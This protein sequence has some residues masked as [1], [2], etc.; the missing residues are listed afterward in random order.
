M[1]RNEFYPALPVTRVTL[2]LIGATLEICTDEIDDIH[3]LIAGDDNAVSALRIQTVGDQLMV[4]QPAASLAKSAAT[5]TWLQVTLRLPC[6]WKGSIDARSVSGW[7]NARGLAGADLSLDSVSGMVSGTDL[8]FITINARTITGD[9]KL[10]G[11]RCEKCSLGSTSGNLAAQ[12]AAFRTAGASTVTGRITLALAEPFEDMS[13][14]AVSGDLR[15][16]APITECD[17]LLRSVSGR[18][19]TRDV[20]ITEDAPRIRATTVSSDLDIIRND[21]NA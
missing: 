14:N 5:S 19:R 7:I 21:L 20:S 10:S 3:V 13:L 8:T 16:E 4:E 9:V 15:V 17:A 11:L 6:S 2:R 1:N 18:I 12:G